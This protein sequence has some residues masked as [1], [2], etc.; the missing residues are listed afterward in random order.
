M[1]KK[2]TTGVG[3][4]RD[5]RVSEKRY[6]VDTPCRDTIRLSV[7][8]ETKMNVVY[9]AGVSHFKIFETIGAIHSA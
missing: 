5:K 9:T 1:K 7:G 4:E 6:N 8:D 3:P 2:I